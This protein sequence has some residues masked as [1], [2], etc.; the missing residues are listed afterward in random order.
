MNFFVN[1]P[2]KPVW[3]SIWI[4]AI[5]SIFGW[6]SEVDIQL[7]DS[8]FIF[9]AV[10]IG[11][12][13]SLFLAVIGL[14]YWLMRNK[15]LVNWMTAVHVG[16]TILSFALVFGIGIVLDK[17]TELDLNFLKTMNWILLY[18]IFL[19][20]LTQLLFGINIAVSLGQDKPKNK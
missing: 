9:P 11:I 12:T 3:Y 2:H 5:L 14:I 15:I 6:D 20:V 19:A 13:F 17:K 16:S 18:L 7:H 4:L 8:Y 10:F 1:T